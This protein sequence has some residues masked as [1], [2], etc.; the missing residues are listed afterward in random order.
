M[1]VGTPA[2]NERMV[3]GCSANRHEVTRELEPIGNGAH[4]VMEPMW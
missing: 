4:L 2:N 3:C 1:V